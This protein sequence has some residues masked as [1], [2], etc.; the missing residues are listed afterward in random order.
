MVAES[1][2]SRTALGWAGLCLCA[3]F[4]LSHVFGFCFM[5]VRC[6]KSVSPSMKQKDIPEADIFHEAQFRISTEGFVSCAYFIAILEGSSEPFSFQAWEFLLQ[7]GCSE[8]PYHLVCFCPRHTRSGFQTGFEWRE[9]DQ[10]VSWEPRI[11]SL[12]PLK[13]VWVA[14]WA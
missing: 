5:T 7:N 4:V 2:W 13:S 6:F 12:V 8:D 14:T 10:V 3:V 1:K 9:L 11:W